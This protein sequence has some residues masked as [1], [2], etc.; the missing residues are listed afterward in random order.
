MLAF[1]SAVDAAFTA[2]SRH[3]LHALL[4][5]NGPRTRQAVAR[6]LD[7]PHRFRT[8][9]L[10]LNSSLTITATGLA[11]ALVAGAGPW[12]AAGALAGLFLAVLVVG[13]VVPKALVM[14]GPTRRPCCS[15][16]R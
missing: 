2:I 7:D 14:R 5:E 6:L 10:V 12:A 1:T 15:P 9:I 11:L 13:E 8:T 16:G 3:R 4:D